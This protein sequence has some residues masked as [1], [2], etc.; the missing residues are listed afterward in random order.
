M[1]IHPTLES[2]Q[3]AFNDWRNNRGLSKKIPEHLWKQVL[4][5]LPHYRQ[6]TILSTLRLNHYQLRKNLDSIPSYQPLS[7]D[8]GNKQHPLTDVSTSTSPFVKAIFPEPASHSPG[9]QIE[10]QRQ[11]G[12]KLTISQLDAAGLHVLIQCWEGVSC[13]H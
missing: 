3:Q 13:Y 4:Q 11:D 1:N 6:K 10:W 5:I 8:L 2:V 7:K 9:Y 12:A